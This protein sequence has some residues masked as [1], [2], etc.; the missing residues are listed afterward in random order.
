MGKKVV[1]LVLL[2]M[3]VVACNSADS[4]FNGEQAYDYLIKQCQIGTREPG[5]QGHKEAK[6]MYLDFF[7]D[8][9]D[10]VFTQ[11]FDQRIEV[12]NVNYKLTNIISGFNLENGDPL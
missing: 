11:E 4:E 7:S 8:W 6:Q 5:S 9:A 10:T 2:I 1:G 3:L 12:D